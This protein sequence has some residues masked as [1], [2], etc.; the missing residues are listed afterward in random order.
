MAR[1]PWR[2]ACVLTIAEV[3][4]KGTSSATGSVR[5]SRPG[6]KTALVLTKKRGEKPVPQSKVLFL[7]LDF[8][9]E[10]LFALVLKKVGDR[11]HGVSLA[12]VRVGHQCRPSH[13]STLYP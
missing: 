12:R 5:V 1:E 13:P 10:G 8:G 2:D 11:A 6:E 3:R 7:P 4:L 9:A